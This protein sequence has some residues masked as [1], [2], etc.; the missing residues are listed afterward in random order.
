MPEQLTPAQLLQR[1]GRNALTL[2]LQTLGFIVAVTVGGYPRT[3]SSKRRPF[4]KCSNGS[5]LDT[6]ASRREG[7]VRPPTGSPSG[8]PG[9]TPGGRCAGRRRM[10]A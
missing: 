3:F 10:A 2:V 5:A 4:A 7:R 9:S 8:G 6:A 1:A